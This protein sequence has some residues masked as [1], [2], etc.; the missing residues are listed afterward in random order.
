MINF[1]HAI[2]VVVLG[3]GIVEDGPAPDDYN[4]QPTFGIW[5]TEIFQ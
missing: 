5:E 3:E 2:K 4:F 1:M